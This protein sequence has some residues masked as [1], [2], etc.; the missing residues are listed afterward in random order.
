MAACMHHPRPDSRNT[1]TWTW[2]IIDAQGPILIQDVKWT[3]AFDMMS[4]MSSHL[5]KT[6]ISTMTF[7][8]RTKWRCKRHIRLIFK[9]PLIIIAHYSSLLKFNSNVFPTLC[10]TFVKHGGCC[11]QLLLTVRIPKIILFY[12]N[13]FLGLS[14]KNEHLAHF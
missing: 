2:Q 9:S 5:S 4:I 10:S 7:E 1:K 14:H 11:E 12:F 6:V 3:D 13:K 8:A